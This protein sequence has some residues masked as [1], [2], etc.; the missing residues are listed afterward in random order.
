[1]GTVIC[2]RLISESDQDCPAP[3]REESRSWE[4][5][6]DGRCQLPFHSVP[7]CS[8]CWGTFW[9]HS[10]GHSR[11]LGW[12]HVRKPVFTTT[13]SGKISKAISQWKCLGIMYSW[14]D[15]NRDAI[16][17]FRKCQD[18]QL[19]SHHDFLQK[20]PSILCTNKFFL[21]Q[22]RL[23]LSSPRLGAKPT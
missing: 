3:V 22:I 1:M 20:K 19:F 11:A 15:H 21:K 6:G 23:G 16:V 14:Q 7:Q 17:C 18:T 9:F 5:W 13:P 8:S 4:E 2:L 10:L 12:V